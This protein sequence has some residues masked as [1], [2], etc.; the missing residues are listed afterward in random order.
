ML[1]DIKILRVVQKNSVFFLQKKMQN[2]LVFVH[3]FLE[4]FD[5]QWLKDI[6]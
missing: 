2:N 3:P 6:W 4:V 5:N 1:K